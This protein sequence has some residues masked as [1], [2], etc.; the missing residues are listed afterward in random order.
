MEGGLRKRE[1]VTRRPERMEALRN[2]RECLVEKEGRSCFR[3]KKS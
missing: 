1:S 2:K 3:L